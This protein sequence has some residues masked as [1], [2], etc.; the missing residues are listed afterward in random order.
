LW[1]TKQVTKVCGSCRSRMQK[2]HV[3]VDK[4]GAV[5]ACGLHRRCQA[6]RAGRRGRPPLPK[7]RSLIDLESL[8]AYHGATL[9]PPTS[10]KHDD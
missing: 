5:P 7:R 9:E 3:D 10:E 1:V 2:A 4:A 8:P 6:L